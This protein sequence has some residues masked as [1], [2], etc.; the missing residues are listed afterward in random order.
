MLGSSIAI[1]VRNKVISS[2]IGKLLTAKNKRNTKNKDKLNA[3]KLSPEIKL[4]LKDRI[5]IE[6]TNAHLKQYSFFETYSFFQKH[7]HK[8]KFLLYAP[9]RRLWLK[10]SLRRTP[11]GL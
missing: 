7:I 3:L 5:K 10:Q 9:F 4:L 6:H 11:F 1:E 8:N 2:N